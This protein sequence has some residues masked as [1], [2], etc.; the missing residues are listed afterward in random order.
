MIIYGYREATLQAGTFEGAVCPHCGQQGHVAGAVFSRHAHIMF[1][2]LFP[3]Y[4]RM[5]VWCQQCGGQSQVA[6]Y[7]PEIQ[8]QMRDFKRSQKPKIWQFL[9]LILIIIFIGSAIIS[10][11]RE[12]ANTKKYLEAPVLNDVYCIRYDDKEYSLMMIAEIE[13][14]SI[15]FHNNEYHTSKTSSVDKLHRADFYEQ[16]VVYGYSKEELKELYQKGS[17]R[18][19]WRDMPYSTEKIKVREADAEENRNNDPETEEDA[20]INT[21]DETEG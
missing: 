20:G 2:P 3:I 21:A 7:P 5:E 19:I 8:T 16:G 4:K 13:G 15:Y 9:G 6:N 11:Q 17:I 1:I 12:K 18:Y 10:G 14:D